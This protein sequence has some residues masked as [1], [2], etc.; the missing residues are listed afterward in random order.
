MGKETWVLVPVLPYHTWTYGSPENRGSP[1]YE[2]VKLFRQTSKSKWN[3]TFQS[4]YKELEEKFN[5]QHIEHPNEDRIPKR[6]NLG[7]GL[8]KIDGFVNVDISPT[9]KPDQIVDLNQFP[10]PF[11]DNEFDHI[12]AKD[13]IEHLGETSKDFISAIKEM[14]RISHNGAI[15][16]VQAPHWR[17]DIAIDDPDHKR[18]ITMGMFNLFNKR[19]ILE[20]LRDGGSDS[21]LAFDHDVDIEI[22]DMQFDYTPPWEERLRKREITQ[23]ELNYALNH[24]NNVALSVKYL[25]Q[26]HKPGRNDFSEYE[27]LIEE[28]SKEPLKLT[29]NDL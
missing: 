28:K 18:L 14:Y 6:L 26:V 3:D 10:W 24:F 17:C 4:L 11:E 22:A 19:M 21:A 29:S 13:I 25:I 12:V 27:K 16:E 8:K 2:T 9:V 20:K 15:W 23:E 7:C 5:L 1:Y